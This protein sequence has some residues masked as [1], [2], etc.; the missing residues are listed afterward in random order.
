MLRDLGSRDVEF[1]NTVA[2]IRSEL[3]QVAG[4]LACLFNLIMLKFFF[5]KFAEEIIYYKYQNCH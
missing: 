5:W 3:L 2:E 1:I 4:T